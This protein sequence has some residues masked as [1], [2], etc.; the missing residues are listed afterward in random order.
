VVSLKRLGPYIFERELGRGTLGTVYLGSEGENAR[1]F[2]VK[3]LSPEVFPDQDVARLFQRDAQPAYALRHRNIIEI[4]EQGFDEGKHYLLM[5]YIPGDNLQ[6]RM[7]SGRAPG[8]RESI[9]IMVKVLQALQYAHDNLVVHCDLKPASI[10]FDAEDQPILTGFGLF[11][12]TDH[13]VERETDYLPPEHTHPKEWDER[14]DSYSAALMLYELLTGSRP[15]PGQGPTRPDNVNAEIPPEV[16]DALLRTLSPEKQNRLTAGQLARQLGEALTASQQEPEAEAEPGEAP[17]ETPLPEI[18]LP[19]IQ[20]Q[21]DP[22][23]VVLCSNPP[24]QEAKNALERHLAQGGATSVEWLPHGPV[25]I[26]PSPLAALETAASAVE[27]F[28]LDKLSASVVTGVF[29]RDPIWAETRPDLGEMACRN[30]DRI[31]GML[32]GTPPGRVRLDLATA[33]TAPDSLELAPIDG[34]V[35]EIH[36]PEPEPPEPPPTPPPTLEE[37]LGTPRRPRTSFVEPVPSALRGQ[38]RTMEVPKKPREP[39]PWNNIISFFLIIF[40]SAAGYFG[41][42][43]TRPGTLVVT[44]QQAS[45]FQLSLDSEPSKS[46]KNGA[47]FELSPGEHSLKVTVKGF[48]P[49]QTKFTIKPRETTK[50]QVTLKRPGKPKPKK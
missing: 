6:Q 26:F 7:L 8:W 13:Q 15:L 3:V 35:M 47:K 20:A 25:A 5:E 32:K 16:S 17:E 44:C 21:P 39:I 19:A 36:H 27:Q 14:T 30:M 22:V 1:Q 50:L 24:E 2:A 45:K 11:Y 40:F 38:S 34:D 29:K 18:F 12:V 41:Y 42:Q 46:Q 4:Q 33:R 49:Y 10:L 48:A 37:R 28:S 23:T 9:R 43:Y 31:H